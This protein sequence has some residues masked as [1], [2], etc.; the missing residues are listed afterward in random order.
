MID[1]GRFNIVFNFEKG[2]NKMG[3]KLNRQVGKTDAILSTVTDNSLRCKIAV[4]LG[5]S[6]FVVDDLEERERNP[7]RKLSDGRPNSTNVLM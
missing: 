1:N 5:F 3:T 7:S 2:E 6:F 4:M